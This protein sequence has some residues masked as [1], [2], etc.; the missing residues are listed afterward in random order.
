MDY[1]VKN[2]VEQQLLNLD[3]HSEGKSLSHLDHLK[4]NA[5]VKPHTRWFLTTILLYNLQLC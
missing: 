5:L 2:P 4:Y 1:L 3:N